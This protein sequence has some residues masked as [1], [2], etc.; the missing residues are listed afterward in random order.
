MA[1]Q[2]A[3]GGLGNSTGGDY[4]GKEAFVVSVTRIPTM[5]TLPTEPQAAKMIHRFHMLLTVFYV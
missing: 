5:A 2:L 4:S 1:R 3:Y